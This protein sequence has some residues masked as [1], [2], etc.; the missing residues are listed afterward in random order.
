MS[1]AMKDDPEL[2]ARAVREWKNN[3]QIRAEFGEL[4]RYHAFL[5]AQQDGRARLLGDAADDAR[6]GPF[7]PKLPDDD[8]LAKRAAREFAAS[9]AIRAE[10]RD[11][12]R[13]YG[14]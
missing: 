11:A 5:R 8:Y 3:P 13:Y 12:P 14:Y 7:D 10:F 4:P 6:G 1:N 2:A 9:A